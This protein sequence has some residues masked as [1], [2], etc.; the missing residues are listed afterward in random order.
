MQRFIA[1]SLVVSAL[2]LTSITG[3]ACGDKLVLTAFGRLRQ[4]RAAHAASILAYTPK[5]SPLTEVVRDLQSQT[6]LK[7]A[8]HQLHVVQDSLQLTSA[9]QTGKYDLLLVDASDAQNLEERTEASPSNPMLLPVLFKGNKAEAKLVEKRFHS[10]LRAPMSA[11]NYL[12]AFD[13]AMALKLK[14][15]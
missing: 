9:L 7:Q 11:G 15:R 12:A 5:D 4:M 2:V 6:A 3:F 14:R 13:D 10:V 1:A 8:G